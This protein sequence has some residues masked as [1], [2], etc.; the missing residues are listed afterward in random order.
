L[1]FVLR[2]KGDLDGAIRES[3][4]AVELDPKLTAAL[5]TLGN[6][7][8]MKGD[9][10][11]AIEAFRKV[12]DIDPKDARAWGNLASSLR[13]KDD[14]DGALE[15]DRHSIAIEPKNAAILNG[16]AWYLATCPD[17]SRRNP[18][19]AVQYAR[20]AIELDPS[21]N[22]FNTLGA[23]LCS[24]GQWSEAVSAL[25]RSLVLLRTARVPDPYVEAMDE[26]I[27]AHAH[28][29]LGDLD[30]A[31]TEIVSAASWL[32]KNQRDP[33]AAEFERFLGDARSAIESGAKR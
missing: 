5:G 22:A 13:A 27:L 21:A 18:A 11:G 16:L 2:E 33:R 31:R 20:R 10:D 3:R 17:P 23:A 4:R 24:A 25:D 29:R 15:A 30:R 14:F 6:E 19:E 7:L 12:I 8:F 26:C 1:S 9:V 32:E 28:A